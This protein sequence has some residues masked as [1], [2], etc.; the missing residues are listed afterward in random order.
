MF[1]DGECW[2]KCPLLSSNIKST[3]VVLDPRQSAAVVVPLVHLRGTRGGLTLL[4]SFTYAA[5]W[6]SHCTSPK[7]C[8]HL[9]CSVLR[10]Y[11]PHHLT[12]PLSSSSCQ[13]GCD[14]VF[15]HRQM[16]LRDVERRC[17]K[18]DFLLSTDLKAMD[19]NCTVQRSINKSLNIVS[20]QGQNL[21]ANVSTK[22]DKDR[23]FF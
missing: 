13:V 3:L 12:A 15:S 21:L 6:L 9:Y 10:L 18:E 1:T 22:R 20:I 2:G 5:L 14:C 8:V 11:Y 17:W 7:V 19:D 23:L 16:D 4:V